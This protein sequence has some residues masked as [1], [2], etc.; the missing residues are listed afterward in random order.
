M[1]F[2]LACISA[3]SEAYG[4]GFLRASAPYLTAASMLA[5]ALWRREIQRPSQWFGGATLHWTL[6]LV[7]GAALLASQ[8][9]ADYGRVVRLMPLLLASA[10]SEEIIFRGDLLSCVGN[11]GRLS[12]LPPGQR[13]I[14]AILLSQSAFTAAH[15]PVVLVGSTM[16][17]S[18]SGVLSVLLAT[19]GFGCLMAGLSL[20]GANV[21]LRSAYHSLINAAAIAAP[22][23]VGLQL[24]RLLTATGAFL[25]VFVAAKRFANAARA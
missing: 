5:T 15:L 19:L 14:T 4:N 18:P 11:S 1:F 3:A 6:I 16:P 10:L 21:A 22:L 9:G 12:A 20:A 25:I 13:R 2:M 7:V 24:T 8:L 23:T 17:G